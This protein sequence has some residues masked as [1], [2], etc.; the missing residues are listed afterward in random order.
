MKGTVAWQPALHISCVSYREKGWRASLNPGSWLSRGWLGGHLQKHGKGYEKKMTA[1]IGSYGRAH[2]W[3]RGLE[4]SPGGGD[5][6]KPDWSDG[7]VCGHG[8]GVGG[9]K[10]V[11]G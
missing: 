7:L 6:V 3:A 2:T 4:G 5:S 9:G 8:Y 11:P 1:V 10:G